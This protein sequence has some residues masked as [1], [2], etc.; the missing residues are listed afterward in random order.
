MTDPAIAQEPGKRDRLTGAASIS[1]T[2]RLTVWYT[3]LTLR[4]EVPKIGSFFA[5]LF[6]KMLRKHSFLS[7]VSHFLW[8]KVLTMARLHSFVVG[9]VFPPIMVI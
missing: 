2:N 1:P 7:G 6:A 8:S 9:V 3:K 5:S 4:V